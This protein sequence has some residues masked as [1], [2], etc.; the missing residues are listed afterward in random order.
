MLFYIKISTKKD[1]KMQQ[2][3]HLVVIII[4]STIYAFLQKINFLDLSYPVKIYKSYNCFL[5]KLPP[6]NL[7]FAFLF[8]NISRSRFH[9]RI[10]QL[11]R[12]SLSYLYSVIY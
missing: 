1:H 5:K 9:S 3:L 6:D 7:I 2:L 8:F 11:Y 10:R 4:H 12:L